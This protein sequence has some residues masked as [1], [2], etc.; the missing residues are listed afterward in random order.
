[1]L[2][3]HMM[4]GLLAGGKV[5]PADGSSIEGRD[6]SGRPHVELTPYPDW[7]RSQR[8]DPHP[9][10]DPHPYAAPLP[11]PV[12]SS[13]VPS[14]DHAYNLAICIVVS[15]MFGYSIAKMKYFR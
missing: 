4:W 5:H 1:M 10:C 13:A 3:H 14:S 9:G 7:G 15:F 12:S 11:G 8:G 2:I 6:D